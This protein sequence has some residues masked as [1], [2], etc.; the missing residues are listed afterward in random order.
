MAAATQGWPLLRCLGVMLG[1]LLPAAQLRAKQEPLW[2]F[3]LGIGALGFEDYR[4]SA[5]AHAYPV[6]VPYVLYNGKFLQADRDGV[7]GKLFNQ[8]WIEVNLSFDATVPVRNDRERSGMPDLKSTVQL[9]PAV[10][11]HLFRSADA[12][13]KLDLRMPVQAA[14]S[15]QTSPHL[16]GWTFTPKLN[17]DLADP[18]GF[19]GWNLGILSGPL[20]ADRR[21]HEYFYTV[22]PQYATPTRPEYHATAGYAGTQVVTALSKRFPR[23]WVG[24]YLRYDTLS[25]AV[26]EDSPLVQRKGYWAAGVG[27]AW[28]I[29]QSSRWV[30]VPD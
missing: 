6:P 25:G 15:V 1:A 30:E 21:Y 7:R 29:H 2:E 11:L 4:G 28:M 8:K 3:G 27:F 12:K 5:V 22:D 14:I 23:F 18:F 24:G 20:F 26:F 19:T 16:V 9:G 10:N 17:L 13:V